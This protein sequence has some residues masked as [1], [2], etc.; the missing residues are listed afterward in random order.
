LEDTLAELL[1]KETE[2]GNV[3][4]TRLAAQLDGEPQLRRLPFQ[5]LADCFVRPI[6]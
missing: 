4:W 5:Q 3:R 1:R 6:R 2:T